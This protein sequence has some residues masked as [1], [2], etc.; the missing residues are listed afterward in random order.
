MVTIVQIKM[1]DT[2]E[3]RDQAAAMTFSWSENVRYAV[4]GF[5]FF[6]QNNLSF[7]ALMH[8]SNSAF[9]LLLNTR[10]ISIAMLGYLM[11]GK[12]LNAVEWVAVVLCTV[13]AT[14]Y[15]LS[16]CTTGEL[17]VSVEGLLIMLVI[18]C[19]AAAGNVYTQ[20]V[21]QKKM[22]QPLMFQNAQ[23]YV[24]GIVFNGINWIFS[25]RSEPAFGAVGA[26]QVLSMVFY[27][28]YGLSISIVLKRFGAMTRTFINAAA[29]VLNA[30]LD[31][32]FF[33]DSISVLEATCFAVILSAIFLYSNLAKD[34]KPAAALPSAT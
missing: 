15:N 34:Y 8:L 16:S 33:G 29:I 31:V 12:R 17:N 9:Q 27:A 28:L 22:N 4:P 10:I 26:V 19:S 24:Y 5:L 7:L 11:L 25:A 18:I 6:V 13:G 23:L 32:T 2:K 20:L 14:Q 3:A 1:G 30:A 21:M